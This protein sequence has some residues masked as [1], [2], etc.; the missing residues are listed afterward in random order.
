MYP[1]LLT[2]P[3]NKLKPIKEEEEASTIQASP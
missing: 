3:L 1:E 2:G